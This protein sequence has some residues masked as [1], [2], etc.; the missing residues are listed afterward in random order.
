MI[1]DKEKQEVIWFI[2][3]NIDQFVGSVFF[4]DLKMMRYKYIYKDLSR[5]DY[6]SDLV[7]LRALRNLLR[8]DY[9]VVI[10]EKLKELC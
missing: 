6:Y 10:S 5:A 8:N 7:Y 3:E 9:P 2:D 1:T 4:T